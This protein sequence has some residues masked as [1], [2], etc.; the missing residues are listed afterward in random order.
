V[1]ALLRFAV[2]GVCPAADL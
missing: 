2:V 1:L